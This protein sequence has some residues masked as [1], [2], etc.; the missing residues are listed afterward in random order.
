MKKRLSLKGML[1]T[2]SILLLVA[3]LPLT[4]YAAWKVSSFTYNK[5]TTPTFGMNIIEE[6]NPPKEGMFPGMSVEKI[7]QVR[8][9]GETDSL[10]RVQLEKHIGDY[11]DEQFVDDENLDV[12]NI[13]LDLNEEDWVNIED[14][15]YYKK[16]LKEGETTTS[17]LKSFSMNSDLGNE[18]ERK[19][20]QIAVLAESVQYQNNGPELWGISY[21]DI[22]VE[23]P[24]ED[25]KVHDTSL[26]FLD[27]TRKFDI[28]V[29]KTD[30]FYNFKD[31]LPGSARTQKVHVVNEYN[32]DVEI[33][34]VAIDTDKKSSNTEVKELLSKYVKVKIEDQDGKTLYKGAIGGK[35]GCD[36]DLGDYKHRD[37]KDLIV[38]L[39]V[40]PEMTTEHQ[41]LMG[42]VKWA[43]EAREI[44]KSEGSQKS[45][46]PV[47]K[48]VIAKQ[49]LVQTSDINLLRTSFILMGIG[50]CGTVMLRR[51]R[52]KSTVEGV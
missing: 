4:A 12:A 36:I 27:P 5:I 8:N 19:F 52:G 11:V 49:K 21:E 14:W 38:T 9:E 50:L 18:Y 45:N 40:D 16:P 46:T 24:K 28:E 30:L 1:R 44:E 22:S 7:V 42:E 25:Y 29:S 3:S 6:F 33:H 48:P 2:L 34:L 10:V 20:V 51:K 31:L 26:R 35:G 17:L 15:Y 37:S 13:T 32:D 47:K 23:E 39:Q 41:N 43:F